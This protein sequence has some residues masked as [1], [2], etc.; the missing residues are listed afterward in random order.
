MAWFRTMST[1]KHAS[2]NRYDLQIYHILKLFED[3]SVYTLGEK[4]EGEKKFPRKCK[5]VIFTVVRN[6][7]AGTLGQ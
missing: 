3:R 1:R 4:R 6:V 7:K 2:A 5:I